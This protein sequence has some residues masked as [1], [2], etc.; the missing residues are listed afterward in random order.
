MSTQTPLLILS[1]ERIDGTEAIIEFSDGTY[2]VLTTEDLIRCARER[3]PVQE[4][5]GNHEQ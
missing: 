5:N 4:R 3:R 2:T 1:V